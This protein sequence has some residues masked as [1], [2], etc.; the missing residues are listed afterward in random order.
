MTS[1][2]VEV[3]D[4][5]KDYDGFRALNKVS[6]NV[7]EGDIF[8][9]IGPNGAGKTTLF[10]ILAT[11]LI[12]TSGTATIYGYD[13]VKDSNEVRKLITYLP[14]DAGIYRN[15]TAYEYLR[16]IAKAYYTSSS[17]VEECVELGVKLLGLGDRIYDKMKTYSKG[18]RRRVQVVRAL[19]IRPKVAILD[20][21]TVGLDVIYSKGIRDL[22]KEFSKTY[23]TTVLIS[24]HNMFEVEGL[25]NRVALISNG[26]LIVEGFTEELIS[27]YGVK[28]LEELFIM[29]VRGVNA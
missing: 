27:K 9:L 12:P 20:E 7:Y 14:E 24:S 6:F 3:K 13:V 26:K 16:L 18:M 17:D 28:N 8:G 29:F 23:G 11:L 15:I 19:M 25:C 2:V 22:I 5:V 21:P 4:L 10:R 1:V